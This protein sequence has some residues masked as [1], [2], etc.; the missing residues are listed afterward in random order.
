MP[1]T[2]KLSLHEILRAD[3]LGKRDPQG[4][5]GQDS[6][7]LTPYISG[8]SRKPLIM[9]Q[10]LLILADT[11]ASPRLSRVPGGG[12]RHFYFRPNALSYHQLFKTVL[13]Q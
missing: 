4:K 10:F 5:T 13:N 7:Q 11:N 8:R 3:G 2:G 12:P 1:S 6:R 9:A